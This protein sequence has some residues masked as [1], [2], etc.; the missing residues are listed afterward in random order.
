MPRRDF[1]IPTR[2]LTQAII[3]K[4]S[5][6]KLGP[7]SVRAIDIRNKTLKIAEHH[8]SGYMRPTPVKAEA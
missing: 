1:T 6:N 8:C 7:A 3:L 5:P 4:D 2:T